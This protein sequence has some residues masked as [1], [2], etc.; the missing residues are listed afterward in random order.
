MNRLATIVLSLALLVPTGPDQSACAAD[1]ESP[2]SST[3]RVSL[4][5]AA[6]QGDVDAVRLLIKAGSDLNE[7]DAYGSTPLIIA[8]TF[9]KTDVANVLIEAGADLAAANNEG[10][11]ALHVAA[12]LG[13]VEI[14]KALLDH[15]ASR[16][17]R[18]NAG[19]TAQDAVAA[20]FE[21]VKDT[22]DAIGKGLAPL[23]LKLDYE[24]IR[25][26][27]PAIAQLLRPLPEDLRAVDYAPTKADDWKV[28]TP[29]D[30]G[31]D[32]RLVAELYFNAADLQTLYG[33]LVVKNGAL[34]AERYFNRGAIDQLSGRQSTTKSFTSALVGIALDRG[35]LSSVEQ[36]MMEFF[37]EFAGQIADSRKMSIT[38]RQLLQMRSGYPW[39]EREPRYFDALFLE[40]NWGWLPHIVDFPL[41]GEPGTEFRYSNLSSHLLAVIVARAC[42]SQLDA[43]AREHLFE[44][45]GAR[46][47]KWSRDADGYN[48]GW[49][50]IYLTARDMARFGR[51]YLKH[52]EYEGRRV[53]SA[54]WV[55]ASLSRYSARIHISGI[56]ASSSAAGLYF[57]DVGYGYQWWS[58]RAGAHRFDFAWGHGGQLIVLLPQFD[59]IIVTTADPLY[60]LPNQ[61]GWPYEVRVID[62]VGRFIN[63]LPTVAGKA[64]R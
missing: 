17:A 58:A 5:V 39:E 64:P 20:P 63:S 52:G 26:T 34:I 33:L 11:A 7:R 60:E 30:E 38:I 57:R 9:G 1:G 35:C 21:N 27:R 61:K 10:S 54:D 22:Y 36:K 18:N 3:A 25:A 56:S 40:G 28:S 55:R 16:Y 41:V 45:I 46:L 48:W 53:I 49:G 15:G 44:P 37:P 2:A 13:R 62:L 59:M 8:A 51:L 31:L 43:Y 24:R 29:A 23:G 32:P 19:H 47:G 50:E 6:L 42:K 4:H 14:V 12:F